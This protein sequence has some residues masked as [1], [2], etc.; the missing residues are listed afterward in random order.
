MRTTMAILT[1]AFA[2]A[3]AVACGNESRQETQEDVAAAKGAYDVS[4]ANAEGAYKVAIERCEALMA[5]AQDSC[6]EAAEANLEA[7]KRAAETMRDRQM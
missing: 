5:D 2:L 1:T 4:I 3:T 7:A 6:K